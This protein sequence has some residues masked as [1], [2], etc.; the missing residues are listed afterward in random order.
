MWALHM[1]NICDAQIFESLEDN[2]VV[3]SREA[4]R[5]VCDI[6]VQQVRIVC[7]GIAW[8]KED[9]LQTF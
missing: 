8:I 1:S 7:Q 4:C 6:Y 3:S 2:G 5:P 9:L